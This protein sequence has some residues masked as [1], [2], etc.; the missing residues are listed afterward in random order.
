[1]KTQA[2]EPIKPE[3]YTNEQKDEYSSAEIE[4]RRIDESYRYI[5]PRP[6]W[7]AARFIAYRLFA[8]PAAFLYCKLALHARFENR[9]VLRKAGKTGCFVYGNPTQQEGD[10]FLPNLAL[11]PKSVY[12]IVHPNNV[13]MQVLGKITPYLG[14]LPLPSN[15]RA[16]R[17]FLDAI[18]P[19]IGEGSFIML[20]PEANIW[21]Y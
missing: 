15:I 19:R 20:Y 1:M 17:S 3:Y 5:D 4:T 6:G 8:M 10:P 13:S 7:K 16:M 9:Q 21:P 12:M 18:R 11:F 2:P 14:A